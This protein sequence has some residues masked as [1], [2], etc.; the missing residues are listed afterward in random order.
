MECHASQAPRLAFQCSQSGMFHQVTLGQGG[1]HQD[2]KDGLHSPHRSPSQSSDVTVKPV[3]FGF[4]EGKCMPYTGIHRSYAMDKST[5]QALKKPTDNNPTPQNINVGH[6]RIHWLVLNLWF[7]CP[8]VP[9]P[10]GTR[11]C[12]VA[13]SSRLMFSGIPKTSSTSAA[14]GLQEMDQKVGV[15]EN[16]HRTA[17]LGGLLSSSTPSAWPRVSPLDHTHGLH[18]ANPERHKDKHTSP[19]ELQDGHAKIED[20]EAAGASS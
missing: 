1:L 11:C 12:Q 14:F 8:P 4:F 13:A 6:D 16:P 15:H 10:S 19:Q 20:R 17:C 9:L 3:S 18:E 2:L 5:N 7:C